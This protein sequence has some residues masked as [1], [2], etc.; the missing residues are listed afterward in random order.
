MTGRRKAISRTRPVVRPRR[1]LASALTAALCL[2]A[3]CGGGDD[4]S[5][6]VGDIDLATRASAAT[7]TFAEGDIEAGFPRTVASGDFNADGSEDILIGAPFADG[8]GESRS[9]GGEAYV[10][11]GPV[12]GDIDLA[13]D[14]PGVTILGA[15]P[16]DNL[17]SGVIS[18]DLNGDGVDDI[19]V[20]ASASDAVQAIRT[21]MGEA[22]VIFGGTSLSGT[23][24][25]FEE[26]QDVT[27]QP[28]EGFS[29]LGRAFAVGDINGD[30]LD[31]LVTGAPYAGREPNTP[32]GGERTTIG[33]VYVFHG[34]ADLGGVITVARDQD[35]A[36]YTGIASYDQ[37]GASVAAADV[38]GDGTDDVIVGAPGYDGPAG[39][40]PEAGGVFVFFGGPNTEPKAI[41]DADLSL[42]GVPSESFGAIVVAGNG[43][44][45]ASPVLAVAAP[46]AVG[47][48]ITGTG[49]GRAYIVQA[50]LLTSQSGISSCDCSATVAGSH[51]GGFF[52]G[53]LAFAADGSLAIGYG[54]ESLLD[55][56]LNGL[57]L[58]ASAEVAETDLAVGAGDFTR[59]L[60]PV[61]G[62]GLGGALTMADLDGDGTPELLV[63]SA[64]FSDAETNPRPALYVVRLPG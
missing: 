42:T 64:K 25:T 41:D 46:T 11:F 1:L 2:V 52:P 63:L 5:S 37:F 22:F 40:E 27:I 10:L 8:P 26:Q 19:I 7:I 36:R 15:R 4:D 47:L 49:T 24:D 44:P 55:R 16:G 57:V 34:R 61:A 56:N 33:E 60:G 45:S 53:A 39:G 21:D 23:I 13:E 14:R 50:A 54:S 3:A 62:G 35:D 18:G 28:A 43:P 20:G 30:G 32:P 31:D 48:S 51:P 6:D 38:N 17:G 59:I 29:Q 12:G 58:L 9:D